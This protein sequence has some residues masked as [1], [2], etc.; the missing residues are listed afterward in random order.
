MSRALTLLVCIAMTA[1]GGGS[2]AL[3][4]GSPTPASQSQAASPSQTTVPAPVCVLPV[5]VI[6][7]G[8]ST[9]FGIDGSIA[10]D[11]DPN[12]ARA[13]HNPGAELQ[14]EMDRIF[15]AGVVKVT[16]IGVP[17]TVAGDAARP[18]IHAP[19]IS[20]NYGLNDA[21][22][23]VPVKQFIADMLSMHPTLIET[24][25][26]RFDSDPLLPVEQAYIAAEKASGVPIADVN[27]YVRSLPNWQQ[28]FAT[29]YSGHATDALYKMVV[30]N[31]L[32]PAIADQVR[33]VQ[34][35]S[36]HG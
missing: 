7:P 20:P 12:A 16:D 29:P 19:I 36:C 23:G 17:G 10:D 3:P 32:A 5:A 27:A 8:D 11:T 2:G 31:V 13:V 22:Y 4:F 24:P 33:Q 1:C 6:L 14:S 34:L 15:G 35:E 18:V 9:Q 25:F 30:D 21:R 28:Y 26:P